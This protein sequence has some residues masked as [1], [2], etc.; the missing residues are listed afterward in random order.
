MRATGVAKRST[1]HTRKLN[2]D[3]SFSA[4]G[5]VAKIRALNESNISKTPHIELFGGGVAVSLLN[6][7]RK[8]FKG[9]ASAIRCYFAFCELE[10]IRPYP[11]REKYGPRRSALFNETET[12]QK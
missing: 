1:C 7:P 12:F 8:A 3:K 6:A 11:I 5:P 2:R 4:L 9:M 10:G